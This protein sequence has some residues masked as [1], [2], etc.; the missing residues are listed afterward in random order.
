MTCSNTSAQRTRRA[1]SASDPRSVCPRGT[2]NVGG[3]RWSG[4]LTCLCVRLHED[5]SATQFN[6]FTSRV[7]SAPGRFRTIHEMGCAFRE[8]SEGNS[9]VTSQIYF[10]Y[11][12]HLL[13]LRVWRDR[14]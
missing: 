6:A 11:L 1:C 2:L 7:N 9:K 10:D 5:S 13:R 14:A 3:W 12:P 4:G 8:R